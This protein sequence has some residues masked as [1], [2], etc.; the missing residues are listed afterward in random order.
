MSNVH[1]H[2]GVKILIRPVIMNKDNS[3]RW[4]WALVKL[5][6]SLFKVSGLVYGRPQGALTGAKKFYDDNC[7][8]ALVCNTGFV[9]RTA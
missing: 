6:G 9:K 2:K 8:F 5:D 3:R 4:T 7:G 1:W